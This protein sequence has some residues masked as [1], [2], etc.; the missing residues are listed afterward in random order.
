L[1]FVKYYFSGA[2]S[3][4]RELIE[5]FI[6]LG[7]LPNPRTPEVI[8]INERKEPEARGEKEKEGMRSCHWMKSSYDLNTIASPYA[9]CP[10]R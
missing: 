10:T 4:E 7:H 3:N 5:A 2:D 1:L 8:S 9:V 6:R